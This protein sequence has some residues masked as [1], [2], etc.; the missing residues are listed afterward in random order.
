[1]SD[2]TPEEEKLKILL[3]QLSGTPIYPAEIARSL[4]DLGHEVSVIV[5]ERNIQDNP[6]VDGVN[7][8]RVGISS[9]LVTILRSLNPITYYRL[10]RKIQTIDPDII[11]ITQGFFWLN[12]VI[13]FLSS[14]PIVYTDHEP[15][16]TN[17]VTFYDR[18]RIYS[19]SKY[20]FRSA[21]D[22]ILVHGEYLK[23]VLENK[24]VSKNKIAVLKHGVYEHYRNVDTGVRFDDPNKK[25]ILFFG[26]IADYKGI[27]VLGDAIPK[28]QSECPE[29]TVT[30][31][32]KGD[33]SKYLPADIA[34]SEFVQIYNE[35]IPDEKVGKFFRNADVVVLPYKS[36]SQSGVLTISYEYRTPVVVT[37][38]G[39][40]PEAVTEGETG[41]IVPSNDP[42]SLS[43]AI[44]GIISSEETSQ[45]MEDIIDEKVQTELSWNVICK[46][47]V[48]IYQSALE[49]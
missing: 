19:Y 20:H 37:N 14:Y 2:T 28:I 17:D 27:D 33:I 39:S 40:L 41:Y 4:H 15:E 3:I 36:G 11:H 46:Q 9:N 6:F 34:N 49:H 10:L 12:P 25:N 48:S 29:A 30:L 45:H 26:L 38:V 1:M 22:K 47:L 31:A 21:A 42:D 23:E 5:S 32:G 24:D 43:E 44:I 35:F 8:H 7:V 16:E 18:T 13:P